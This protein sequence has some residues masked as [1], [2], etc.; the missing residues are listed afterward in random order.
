MLLLHPKLLPYICYDKEFSR[1]LVVM[2][3][4]SYKSTD[5]GYSDDRT[6]PLIKAKVTQYANVL[7]IIEHFCML[8]N[9]IGP[10]D[11]TPPLTSFFFN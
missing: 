11:N 8:Y 9:R 10:V 1:D 7:L 3:V 4:T 6:P 2:A 5:P